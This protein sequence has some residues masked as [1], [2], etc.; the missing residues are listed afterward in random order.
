[1]YD[2]T[3]QAEAWRTF[4]TTGV[5]DEEVVRPEVARSWLRCK[6]AGTN[7]WSST[8]PQMNEALLAE[9]R[10]TY[11]HSLEVNQPVM[12][13]LLALL[14]C[15]VSLMDQE[16]FVFEFFSPLSYY[17][18]TFG[19][20][21]REDEAGTGNATVVAYERKPV[22][23]EG[24]EQYRAIAQTY[25]GV[26]APYLDKDGNYFG[27]LNLNDPF[28]SLPDCALDMCAMGIKLSNELFLAGRKMW[29]RLRTLEFFKP[30]VDLMDDRV[31]ILDPQGHILL[32]NEAM[33]PFMPDVES[34]SYGSQ[35][36]EAYLAKD[37]SLK[38]LMETPFHDGHTLPAYF[39]LPGRK[40]VR[41]LDCMHRNKVQFRNGM[42][43]VVFVF[44]GHDADE[45]QPASDGGRPVR[46]TAAR[47]K[48]ASNAKVN[49]IGESEEWKEVDRV[50]KR[51]APINANVLI[52][53]ETGTGKEVVARAIHKLSG[54]TGN[55]VAVNC[56]AIP[57][58]LFAAEL[59][60]YESGAF[61][62]AK[63]GGSTGKIEAADHG[64]LLLDEIGEMPL[65]LQVT[66]LR[67]IQER[68]VVRLGSNQPRPLDV[69]F[70]AATNQSLTELIDKRLFRSDLYYRLSM[71]EIKL[72]PLRKRI[73]DVPLLVDYF[74]KQLSQ[75]LQLRYSPF[76]EDVMKAFGRYTWPGN[77]RE[78]RNIVERCLILA[79][80]GARVSLA[81]VPA[82]IAN[83]VSKGT[84]YAPAMTE[85]D[86]WTAASPA[87]AG[88][89]AAG[90]EAGAGRSRPQADAGTPSAKDRAASAGDGGAS[91][92]ASVPQ[93]DESGEK[94]PPEQEKERKEIA[95]A[96]MRHA[97]NMSK[98]AAEMG[99]S[100]TTLYKRM[101]RFHLHVRVVVET[102]DGE[103]IG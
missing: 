24:F 40:A 14:Q 42:R 34:F 84:A 27:A 43:F 81:D 92:E 53:G 52:L 26:S 28:E 5:I 85:L 97:G 60:G 18:R 63:E 2:K 22:R 91:T 35:S 31:L 70:L 67:V 29:T 95:R 51:V 44:D 4:I 101:E 10:Q 90:R 56:G 73:D 69:R 102:D 19:T 16:N 36:V 54:R 72:P 93:S 13:M 48:A 75:S 103:A 61:T 41:R 58:D 46:A 20:Y 59:F 89:G 1:M 55:F 86:A 9:K 49:Y 66:L 30:L 38:S 6:A 57:R 45:S 17:P 68:S 99:V 32:V 33:K 47:A 87:Q 88:E 39:Q 94:L 78:L 77:V 21:V 11:E 96:L 62:G 98:A 83:A 37:T 25:C 71:I 80:E 76:P 8:F 23:I 50:V 79:G 3:K 82:S 64:T 100:R 7:P 15:N 12:R 74:N 65:D